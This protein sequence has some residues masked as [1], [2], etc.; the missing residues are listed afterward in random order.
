[1]EVIRRDVFCLFSRNKLDVFVLFSSA[2]EPRRSSFDYTGVEQGSLRLGRVFTA[3]NKDSFI[4][5]AG[6]YMYALH[7]PHDL[8]TS[9]ITMTRDATSAKLQRPEST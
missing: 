4:F 7:V 9:E 6:S 1:V 3:M 2:A 8:G 5:M